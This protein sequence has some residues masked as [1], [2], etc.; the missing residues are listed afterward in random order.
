MVQ[1][2]SLTELHSV[3]HVQ[4]TLLTELHSYVSIFF[5][6]KEIEGCVYKI[7]K[8]IAMASL[9]PTI[10]RQRQI[11]LSEFQASQSYI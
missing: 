3:S 9:I 11:D 8:A 6:Y 10:R 2:D 7:E 5:L 4:R 1:K